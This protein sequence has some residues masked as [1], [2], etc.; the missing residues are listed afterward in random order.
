MAQ[1]PN[2]T[3]RAPFVDNVQDPLAKAEAAAAA[4]KLNS[5]T[6]TVTTNQSNPNT[7]TPANTN[8][9]VNSVTILPKPENAKPAEPVIPAAS[10]NAELVYLIGRSE[11]NYLITGVTKRDL[12]H[13]LG[14][15]HLTVIIVPFISNGLHKGK[16][17]VHDRTAK[18][19]AT[20]VANGKSP[21]YNLFGG[22]CIAD[23]A[24]IGATV[25]DSICKEEAK[26]ELSEEL[27]RKGG[28]GSKIQLEIWEGGKRQEHTAQAEPYKPNE[29][30]PIGITLN[31]NE[32]NNECSYYFALPVPES[33]I[34]GG[35]IGF[36]DAIP[37]NLSLLAADSYRLNGKERNI[38]L[39]IKI[40]SELELLKIP[41]LNPKTEICDAITRLWRPENERVY[42]TLKQYIQ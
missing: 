7:T 8:N 42:K 9:A 26:R 22:H 40:F 3:F 6:K 37:E 30:I 33:D 31:P 38:L 12:A 17:I 27:F 25:T 36:S 11:G 28:P 20:R 18:L 1:D 5:L 41:Y 21:S 19:E 39:P 32:H 15:C 16:F 35:E 14:L 24:K 34:F 4:E 23:V 10:V 2:K 29:L 13:E